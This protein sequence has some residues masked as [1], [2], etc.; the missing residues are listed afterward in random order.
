MNA[1]YSRFKGEF[2]GV[3]D[4]IINKDM[5]T[6]KLDRVQRYQEKQEALLIKLPEHENNIRD[7]SGKLDVIKRK[8]ETFENILFEKKFNE[9][10]AVIKDSAQLI[11]KIQTQQDK[12][13]QAADGVKEDLESICPTSQE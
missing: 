8:Y 12:L 7:V 3:S 9:T 10:T 1:N 5:L 4:S 13:F 6:F 11:E 2:I